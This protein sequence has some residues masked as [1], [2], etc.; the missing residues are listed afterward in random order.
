LYKAANSIISDLVYKNLSSCSK[1][2]QNGLPKT[3]THLAIA[4]IAFAG[5]HFLWIFFFWGE[6]HNTS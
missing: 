4:G 3:N 2:K 5:R 1:Y 6:I